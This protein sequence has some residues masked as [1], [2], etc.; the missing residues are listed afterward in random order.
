MPKIKPLDCTKA[1]FIKFIEQDPMHYGQERSIKKRF[2]KHYEII[3]K[4]P[5]G[6]FRE[7]LYCYVHDI[8]ELPVCKICGSPVKFSSITA[9][10]YKYCCNKCGATDPATITKRE[11]TCL[12]RYGV[13]TARQNKDINDK[14]KQTCLE[15]YGVENPSQSQLIKDK[16]KR[17]T[18]KH[19]GVE[20]PSQSAEVIAKIKQS[21]IDKYRPSKC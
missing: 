11:Q 1:E 19:Y 13:K 20:N 21:H 14:A 9:G 5:G 15:K 6:G 18:I 4:C 17:T 8:S 10:F 2:P 16:K 3:L 7:K 12:K